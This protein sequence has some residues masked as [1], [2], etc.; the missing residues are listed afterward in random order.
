MRNH[1]RVLSR[2]ETGA[3]FHFNRLTLASVG[4]RMEEVEN[5]G[6]PGDHSKAIREIRGSNSDK[7]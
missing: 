7:R 4:N 1:C 2:G 3:A 6:R 5:E